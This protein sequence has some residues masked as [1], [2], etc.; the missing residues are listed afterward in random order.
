MAALAIIMIFLKRARLDQIILY[1]FIAIALFFHHCGGMGGGMINRPSGYATIPGL[2][3]D[4]LNPGSTITVYLNDGKFIQGEYIGV[5]LISNEEYAEQYE[6]FLENLSD[7]VYF[8][9]LHD[10]VTLWFNWK[11]RPKV[12]FLGF[13]FKQIVYVDIETNKIEAVFL[14][15]FNKIYND[16]DRCLN[17][18]EV[19]ILMDEN[20][21][22]DMT[23]VI[24]AVNIETHEIPTNTIKL[25]KINA[26]NN[27]GRVAGTTGAY[28]CIVGAVASAL[29]I[30][31]MV[32]AGNELFN[33][34]L[35]DPSCLGGP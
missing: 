25:I 27:M 20:A 15:G 1:I 18:K 30:V 17:A 23:S 7:S 12:E 33:S 14:F 8:P 21:I 4:T 34:C 10:T 28:C 32:I 29:I 9:K 35:A 11:E 26:R 2:I 19:K 24:L 5:K 13:R 31:P 22:P 3:R 6:R 16:Q